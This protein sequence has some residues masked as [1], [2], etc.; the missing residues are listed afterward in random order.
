LAS[1]LNDIYNK[2]IDEKIVIFIQ[3]YIEDEIIR[4]NL[5]KS[6]QINLEKRN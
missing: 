5:E 4:T 6:S 3:K 1:R 2:E